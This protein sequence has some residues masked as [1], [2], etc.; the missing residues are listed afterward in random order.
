MDR[1]LLIDCARAAEHIAATNA[2]IVRFD[3]LAP[4][5][6]KELSTAHVYRPFIRILLLYKTYAVWERFTPAIHRT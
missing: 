3:E 2:A 1:A 4:A 6:A 5:E